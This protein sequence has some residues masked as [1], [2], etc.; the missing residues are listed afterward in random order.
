[1]DLH[2]HF[3]C[4]TFGDGSMEYT[5]GIILCTYTANERRCYIVTPPLMGWAY[6]QNDLS[7][8]I[9]SV[10]PANERWH[11]TVCSLSLAGRIHRMIPVHV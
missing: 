5:S 7:L 4:S 9:L 1:M 11:Y 6:T 3:L 8:I 10:H 2:L